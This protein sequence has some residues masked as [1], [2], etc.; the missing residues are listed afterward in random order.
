[1]TATATPLPPQVDTSLYPFESHYIQLSAGKMHYIDE[2][3]GPV[4]LFVHGTP[5]WSFLYRDFVKQLSNT[6]RCIAIDHLGFG[7]SEKPKNF[8]GTPENHSKNLIELV[9]RLKL[10]SFTLVVHDFGG[11]IGFGLALSR[12]KR[13]ANLVLFNTW[14]WATAED[15]AVEKIDK[16]IN[17]SMGRFLY[18]QLNFSPKV[19]LKKGF[20]D[21]KK[22]TRK[23]HKHYLLPFPNSR[24]RKG[25]YTLAQSLKA[26]SSWYEEKWKQ[27]DTLENTK[28]LIIWGTKDE[29]LSPKYL[30]RWKEKLPQSTVVELPCGHFVQEEMPNEAILEIKKMITGEG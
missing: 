12:P 19:L 23:I 11:P 28:I 1:M 25:P 3:S 29:F 5:T 6:H 30:M 18:F 14:L 17:S 22:L 2:G 13:V 21:R 4:I 9:D 7:L 26:S 24:S 27:L 20:Y 16:L 10:D 15:S 8:D